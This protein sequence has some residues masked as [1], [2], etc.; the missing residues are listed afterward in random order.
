[1]TAYDLER[2]SPYDFEELVRDLLQAEWNV[3]LE[4]FTA[5]RDAGIDLRCLRGPNDVVIVQCKHTAG[6]TFPHLLRSLRD[7]ELP[8]VVAL[9]PVRYL[10][11]TSTGLTPLN[12][13]KIAE[14]FSPFM[15]AVSDILGRDDLENLLRR[16]PA[17]EVANFKLWLTSTAVMRRVLHNAEHCQTD[18]EVE[19]VLE[20]L[21]LFVQNDGFPRAQKILSDTHTVVISGP[22]GIG[23]T[24]L[25]D[26]LL[27]AHLDQGF[28]PVVVQGGIV[29]AK[30]LF[31][32]AK[33]QI[34]YFDDFLGS[35]FFGG[36]GELI[37]RNQDA[38]LIAFIEAVARSPNTRFVLTTR[39][40]V[41]RSALKI[42]ERLSQS[43][44]LDHRCL[45]EM[46]HYTYSQKAR[47]LYNHLYFSDLPQRYR[48]EIV[49]GDFYLQVVKHPNFV[50][51]IIEW[52][53]GYVRV[54]AVPPE[55]Y[56][57][58][59]TELLESPERIWSHAFNHQISSAGRNLLLSMATS[60]HGIEI[61]DLE[62]VWASL[63][64]HCSRKYNFS[65]T[66]HDFR[67]ALDELEGSFITITNE[68]VAFANPSIHDFV[69]DLIRGSE[70]HINDQLDSAIRF[71]QP[72]HLFDLAMNR[73]SIALDANV[74]DPSP[75]LVT[76]LRRVLNGP[77]IRW[78]KRSHGGSRG[79]FVDTSR[80][81]RLK[82]L[83][84]WSERCR[85]RALVEVLQAAS[86]E[87]LTQWADLQLIDTTSAIH[88]IEALDEASWVQ[89]NT[90]AELRVAL[91]DLVLQQLRFARVYDWDF[92]IGY[93]QKAPVWDQR[94]EQM[95]QSRL[96]RY[97]AD[98][99][100]DEA[101]ECT[102]LSDLEELRDGLMQI[103]SD[104]GIPLAAEI[105][106]VESRLND[107]EEPKRSTSTYEDH[108]FPENYRP[109]EV[110]NDDEIRNLFRTLV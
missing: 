92:M 30:R 93:R 85:S 18:F 10:I 61:V 99:I 51:R 49:A 17:V 80:E 110:S 33:R 71:A 21:P 29:E 9:K 13:D 97:K 19:R 14:L 27:Y 109:P 39:E 100:A 16:N 104:R 31:D 11:A 90:G 108:A 36:H 53:S 83:V 62:P 40:H 2:L 23:K 5:G 59:V 34:F 52:L 84:E 98:G 25:A 79:I 46:G 1:M 45:L 78:A 44:L 32:K 54:K 7:V 82:F 15:G 6:T 3:R 75:K 4:S 12:K 89:A 101:A 47:I 60:K 41:L 105:S 43:Q 87:F 74:L 65:T 42:S 35:T 55:E 68:R 73:S 28:E 72:Q 70:E 77:H 66:P 57:T 20:K 38:S 37:D 91:L 67:S 69:D 94:H 58:H 81:S 95:L 22:P 26:M 96:A 56:R 8:K 63:H 86:H 103:Q 76:C 48:E 64:Q 107:Y 102:S 88:V 50:P 106:M 24:T